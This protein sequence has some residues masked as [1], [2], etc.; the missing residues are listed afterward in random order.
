MLFS[1]GPRASIILSLSFL[2]ILMISCSKDEPDT[3]DCN[4]ITPTYTSNIKAI[5]DTNCAKSGCHD[6]ITVQS[7]VNL[8]TYATASAISMED[9]F[10]GVIQHKSGYPPMP[11]DGPKLPDATVEQL[12]CWVQN[13]SPE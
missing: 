4:G 11:N 9:R 3:I 6:A 12:T 10:L 8:S 13:G 7:G 2:A 1:S 5:L